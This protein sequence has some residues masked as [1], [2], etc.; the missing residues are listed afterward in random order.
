MWLFIKSD[1]FIG[2]WSVFGA[3]VFLHYSQFFIKGDF[4]I[5]RV[6]CMC[7]PMW[8]HPKLPRHCP[9]TVGQI[10]HALWISREKLLASKATILKAPLFWNYVLSHKSRSFIQCHT[11]HKLIVSVSTSTQHWFSMLGTLDPPSKLKWPEQLTMLVY[12]YNCTRSTATGFKPFFLMYGM[13]TY[14]RPK[15]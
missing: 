14:A 13:S 15:M 6:E 5:G 3:E 11:I 4:V 8:L 12:A 10:F 2:E 1:V 7:R 9:G